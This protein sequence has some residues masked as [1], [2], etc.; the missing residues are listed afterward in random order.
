MTFLTLR[1][2]YEALSIPCSPDLYPAILNDCMSDDNKSDYWAFWSTPGHFDP[3]ISWNKWDY[4]S[5][6]RISESAIKLGFAVKVPPKKNDCY[7]VFSAL[8]AA[9]ALGH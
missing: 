9:A 8:G 6:L 3:L 2:G 4:K 7:S 5:S 1:E